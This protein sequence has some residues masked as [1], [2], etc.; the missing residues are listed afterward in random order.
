MEI[1]VLALYWSEGGKGETVLSN[2]L[3]QDLTEGMSTKLKNI[4]KYKLWATET[5]QW[6]VFGSSI[7]AGVLCD[8]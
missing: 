4:A 8:A 1:S 5:P 3:N 7:K 6:K 2:H